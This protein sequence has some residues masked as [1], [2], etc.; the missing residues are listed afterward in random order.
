[1]KICKKTM[2]KLFKEIFNTDSAFDFAGRL[3]VCENYGVDLPT[4]W[5]AD[6]ILP[7]SK[8]GKTTKNNIAIT[9]IQTNQIKSDRT[10]WWDG[11]KKYQV[12]KED[13]SK[14]TILCVKGEN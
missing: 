5:N 14:Y 11:E 6:H 13:K 9:N 7:K 1:M 2:T 12:K 3:M 10:T 4:G 8:G